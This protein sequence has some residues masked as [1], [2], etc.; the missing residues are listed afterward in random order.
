MNSQPN[1]SPLCPSCQ[2]PT[3]YWPAGIGRTSG[4]P[5]SE[6]WSCQDENCRYV[7]WGKMEKKPKPAEGSYKVGDMAKDINFKLDA[8]LAEIKDLRNEQIK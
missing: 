8:I 5:Y 2:A 7:V 3:K 4:K 1:S 6:H